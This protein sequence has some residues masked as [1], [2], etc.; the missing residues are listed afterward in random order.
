MRKMDSYGLN[1]CKFQAELF[2]QSKEGRAEEQCHGRCSG[3]VAGS[4]QEIV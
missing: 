2:E 1:L 4:E 3:T